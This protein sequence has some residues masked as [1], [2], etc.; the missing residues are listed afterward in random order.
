MGTREARVLPPSSGRVLALLAFLA[1]LSTGGRAASR[2]SAA[3]RADIEGYL[4]ALMRRA[5]IPGLVASVVRPAG[6]ERFVLGVADVDTGAPLRTDSRFE[7]GS[8][9]KAFTGLA[10]RLLEVRGQLDVNAPIAAQLPWLRLARGG[11]PA[12]PLVRDF[13]F[14]TAG[15]RFQTIALV[16]RHHASNELD[17]TVRSLVGERTLG[18]PG[19]R[20]SYATVG[21]DVL[22]LVIERLSGIPYGAFIEREL[23]VPLRLGAT[24][25]PGATPRAG[26]KARGHKLAFGRPRT[27]DAPIYPGHAPAA[28]VESTLEDMERWIGILT[29]TVAVP[30]EL[31]EAL[32]RAMR[33][34]TSVPPDPAYGSFYASGWFYYQDWGQRIA[35]GGSNP[36]FSSCV[37]VRP[38][39]GEGVVVLAN[40]NAND[41]GEACRSIDELLHAG[42]TTENVD[43]P[44]RSIDR[45]C[46]VIVVL[47]AL[48]SVALL[49]SVVWRAHLVRAGLRVLD[50][51]RALAAHRLVGY[52]AAVVLA[53]I[54][55]AALPSLLLLGLPWRVLLEWGPDSLPVAVAVAWGVITLALARRF[56]HPEEAHG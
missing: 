50:R 20:F 18:L 49:L 34:D 30:T 31:R 13:L 38:A 36:S 28:Y 55:V 2:P 54:G 45:L 26:A 52:G 43:D 35:H 4:Q 33:P 44:Y 51:R 39:T 15:L 8:N 19:E 41:V 47:G 21:Y 12:E 40:L 24:T 37:S 7:L 6:T 23:L 22:G 32:S 46:T 11:E 56:L 53:G 48:G 3:G 1:V 5:H 25:L 27:F 14:H 42:T 29:G 16:R 10:I 17:A 9:S